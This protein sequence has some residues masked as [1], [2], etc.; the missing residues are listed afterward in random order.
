MTKEEFEALPLLTAED[1]VEGTRYMFREPVGRFLE[2]TCVSN[3][4]RASTKKRTE[5]VAWLRDIGP[6]TNRRLISRGARVGD[7]LCPTNAR[8]GLVIDAGY[9][10]AVLL[11]QEGPVVWLVREIIS[12][13]E[14]PWQADLD[15]SDILAL[16]EAEYAQQQ[17]AKAEDREPRQP[18]CKCIEEPGDSPCEVHP[19]CEEC[20]SDGLFVDNVC[21]ACRGPL[22]ARGYGIPAQKPER[23]K[24]G[25]CMRHGYLAC[26]RCDP[27]E[28]MTTLEIR[29]MVRAGAPKGQR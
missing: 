5:T 20:G 18:G 26:S 16:S 22:I 13:S 2:Y 17:Q 12:R 23:R 1:C 7:R 28:G 3:A 6:T 4:E 25:H 15:D 19:S 10:A 21:P 27:L 11:K 14:L 24:P 29:E 8:V 9:D